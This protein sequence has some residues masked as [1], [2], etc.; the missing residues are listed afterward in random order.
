MM[1]YFG[2][3]AQ[4][5]VFAGSNENVSLEKGCFDIF[6]SSGEFSRHLPT[7]NTTD[8]HENVSLAPQTAPHQTS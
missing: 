3:I 5:R 8:T 1:V 4:L 2:D 7:Q 6:I